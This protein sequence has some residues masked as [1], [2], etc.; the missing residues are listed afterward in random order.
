[1][2]ILCKVQGGFIYAEW[3]DNGI[4]D[5]TEKVDELEGR[6]YEK[7]KEEHD[8]LNMYTTFKKGKKEVTVTMMLS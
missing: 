2:A 4:A 3:E 6:G 1:M 8:Y 5:L 7:V